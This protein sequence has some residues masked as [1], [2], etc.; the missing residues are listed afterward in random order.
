MNIEYLKTFVL[1]AENGSFSKTAKEQVVVQS[2]V[3]SRISELEREV[4]QKLFVRNRNYSELTLA[5]KALLEYAEKIISLESKAIAQANLAGDYSEKLIIGTVYS[6]YDSHLCE[7][8]PDFIEENEDVS[9][10]VVF[11]HSRR[12]ISG[13]SNGSIDIGYSH[14][15]YHHP[16]YICMLFNEDDVIFVTGNQ[17][18]QF[19]HGVPVSKIKELPVY[20]SNFLYTTTHNWIFP[21]NKLFRLDIDIASK[22][23]P[24]L[25]NG[26]N[27]T[28]LP[29]K[30]IEPE[31]KNG[32]VIEIPVLDGKI[33]PV[34]NYIIY[35]KE[36]QKSNAVQKWLNKFEHME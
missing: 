20:Y 19:I 22:I 10:R 21:K 14:N 18:K 31:I 17:N 15:P 33:P 32:S 24:F 35:K 28:F 7:F 2:T 8:I 34:Q 4:G 12:I 36:A 3:S 1:L 27:Y 9:I 26:E 23:I 11:G 5:G 29:R 16:S 25:K 6:L 30:I 13:L